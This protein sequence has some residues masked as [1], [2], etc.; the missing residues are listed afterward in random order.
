MMKSVDRIVKRIE[1]KLTASHALISR[2]EG[3]QILALPLFPTDTDAPS[4]YNLKPLVH[5]VNKASSV[6]EKYKLSVKPQQK[7]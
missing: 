3:K 7:R 2:Q 5:H 4:K 1:N 6:H